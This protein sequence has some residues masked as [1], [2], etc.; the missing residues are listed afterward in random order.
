[1]PF[2]HEIR[3]RYGE[4]DA[5]RVVFNAHWLAYIDD[6]LTRYLEHLGFDPKSTFLEESSGFDVM[7]VKATLE[8]KGPAGFDDL[9]RIAVRPS[10]LGGS[11]FDLT[12]TCEVD[13][14][15]ILE[16]VVTYVSVVPGENRSQ[17]IPDRVRAVLE[18]E[19]GD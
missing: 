1:M 6:A 16:A 2:I 4:V 12:Y 13:G 11:S 15:P 18:S 8:W 17:P 3:V 14:S 5:Q 10:R 19:A 7:L 9:V